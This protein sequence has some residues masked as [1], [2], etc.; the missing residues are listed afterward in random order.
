MPKVMLTKPKRAKII[1]KILQ[2][3]RDE[4]I[5][6]SMKIHLATLRGYYS[7]GLLPKRKTILTYVVK[8]HLLQVGMAL[9]GME[10]IT[11]I[12]SILNSNSVLNQSGNLW[13]Y[14]NLRSFCQK[15]GIIVQKQKVDTDLFVGNPLSFYETFSVSELRVD[16]EKHIKVLNIEDNIPVSLDRLSPYLKRTEVGIRKAIA[17]G[18]RTNADI[19]N[20]LNSNGY[21]NKA[22]KEFGRWSVVVAMEKLGIQV[23][24]EKVEWG[25]AEKQH[26]IGKVSTYS[27]NKQ[28]T[29]EMLEQWASELDSEKVQITDKHGLV[30]SVNHLRLRHNK[31]LKEQKFYK[32]WFPK[33]DYAVNVTFRHKSAS[34]LDLSTHFDLCAMTIQRHIKQLEYD[35]QHQY[36]LRFKVLYESYLEQTK[37][38][39]WSATNCAEWFNRTYLRTERGATWTYLIVQFSIDKL[40]KLEDEG[41][42]E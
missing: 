6:I 40:H 41:L 1:G 29:S 5:A 9:G 14:S 42:Y 3:K 2:G 4:Q 10:K 35:V 19:T 36:F 38:E 31:I 33:I 34:R 30:L 21:C 24:V 39:E 32:E 27:K 16:F 22:N 18:S 13:S 7:K 8:D 23:P 17:K 37:G 26:L 25:N 20:Y 28:I 15:N 11:T 12:V